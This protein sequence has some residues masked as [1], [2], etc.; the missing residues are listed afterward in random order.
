MKE[1]S[2]LISDEEASTLYGFVYRVRF[3]T[4]YSYVGSKSIV[5]GRPWKKYKTSC[6]EVTKH[7][8]SC[9]RNLE[10]LYKLE[11]DDSPPRTQL[12]RLHMIESAHIYLEAANNNIEIINSTDAFRKHLPQL[13]VR[14]K[15]DRWPL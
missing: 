6:P 2:D 4:V 5:G 1:F 7:W 3:G 9:R 8:D 11:K 15:H 14:T 12:K 10:I 13:S